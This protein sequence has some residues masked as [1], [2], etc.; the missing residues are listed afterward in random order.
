MIEVVCETV[1]ERPRRSPG[2]VG[3]SAALASAAGIHL[4]LVPAH[5]ARH[6]SH[7]A[8]FLVAAA[9][10][11]A[12]VVGLWRHPSTRVIRAAVLSV[13]GLVAAWIVTQSVVAPLASQD[14]A[15]PVDLLAVI[16]TALELIA[17]VLLA[18][19][20]GMPTVQ[21]RWIR[22]AVAATSGATFMGLYLLASGALS[23]A[24]LEGR[25]PVLTVWDPGLTATTPLVYGTLFPHVWLVGSWA[26]LSLTVSAGLLVTANVAR[27]LTPGS[28]SRHAPRQG[29]VA[30]VPLFVG[31][32]SCC[33]APLALFLGASS[34]GLLYQATPWILLGVV[35]LLM[36]NLMWPTGPSRAPDG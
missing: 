4:L 9:V 24:P 31:V 3:A 2:V 35:A 23:Y 33:G 8:F 32:S 30:A 17:V 16:A 12:V 1:P 34:I 13:L 26:T 29:P 21:R 7:G 14:L 28:G 19:R 22:A 20:S 15:E 18:S 11:F 6:V 27:L 36:A 25:A 10:Q 5:A